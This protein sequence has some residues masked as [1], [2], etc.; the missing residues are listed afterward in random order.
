VIGPRTRTART[1][2]ES[3][4][5][6]ARGGRGH[7]RLILRTVRE[8]HRAFVQLLP[9]SFHRE[10]RSRERQEW[11][12]LNL[13]S[14]SLATVRID[15]GAAHALGIEGDADIAQPRNQNETGL[16]PDPRERCDGTLGRGGGSEP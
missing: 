2:C 1:R 12:R 3:V 5:Q 11:S 10:S 16:P 8:P 6:T 13:E 7:R 4:A 15:P 14:R 9:T